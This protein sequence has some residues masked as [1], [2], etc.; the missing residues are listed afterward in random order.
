MRRFLVVDANGSPL[1]EGFHSKDAADHWINKMQDRLHMR[2][3]RLF[4]VDWTEVEIEEIEVSSRSSRDDHAMYDGYWSDVARGRWD[5][6]EDSLS[7]RG[8]SR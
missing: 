2:H 8:R 5:T 4:S 6:D 1:H 3:E 7:R